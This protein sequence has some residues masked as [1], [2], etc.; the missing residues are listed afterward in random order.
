M[1]FRYFCA[2]DILL[3]FRYFCG[4]RLWFDSS[5]GSPKG[6]HQPRKTRSVGKTT[7]D[8]KKI[9]NT[10]KLTFFLL[11]I[12]YM[13]YSLL[14]FEQRLTWNFDLTAPLGGSFNNMLLRRL[15]ALD[16][17]VGVHVEHR[18]EK[19]QT[20]SHPIYMFAHDT[21]TRFICLHIIYA[22]VHCNS[23]GWASLLWFAR[24]W[25]VTG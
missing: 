16:V 9:W 24:L 7:I 20:C 10:T 6:L 23:V 1:L 22:T 3:L 12:F 13:K 25:I 4:A 17:R 19:R 8:N 2:S 15:E 21:S 18:P 11:K 5:D 14:G